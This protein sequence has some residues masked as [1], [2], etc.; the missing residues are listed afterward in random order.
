MY[1]KTSESLKSYKTILSS[2]RGSNHFDKEEYW[3]V[4]HNGITNI[5][6]R[7]VYCSPR[8]KKEAL[9]WKESTMR[10]DNV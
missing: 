1:E 9:K 4:L 5:I 10:D 7:C 2:I 6:I 8:A 3:P